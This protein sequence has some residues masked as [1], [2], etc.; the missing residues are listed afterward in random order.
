MST[1][2]VALVGVCTVNESPKSHKS[3]LRTLTILSQ[4][5]GNLGPAVLKELLDAGF[6][7]TVLTRS[8]TSGKFDPRATV[9]EVDYIST[10]SLTS[11]L[12][13]HQAVFNTLGTVALDIHLPLIDSAIAANVK[14][15]IPSEFGCNTTNLRAAKLPV[16]ADKITVQQHLKRLA[17]ETGSDFSYTFLFTGPFLDWGLKTGFLLKLA[18][19]SIEIYGGGDRKVST[20]TLS[21][22][23]KAVSGILNDL[24]ATKNQA[25]FVREADITQNQLLKLAGKKVTVEHVS[26]VDLERKAYK[27]LGKPNPNV[28][29]LIVSFIKRCIFGEGYGGHFSKEDLSNDSLGIKTLSDG[30]L[31]AIVS[32]YAERHSEGMTSS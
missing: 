15:F 14:R 22:V 9:A 7:V 24:N 18:G 32:K 16:Y 30:E 10:A 23:G 21:G 26:T 11:A 6:D 8:K 1:L 28:F 3:L 20:T 2:K 12:V 27:E 5:S 19:P 17:Q 25:L 4:A 13:D 31:Q 29:F